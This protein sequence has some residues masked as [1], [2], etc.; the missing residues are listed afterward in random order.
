[1]FEFD[2]VLGGVAGMKLAAHSSGVA[3]I[4]RYGGSMVSV[5][6]GGKMLIFEFSADGV[7]GAGGGAAGQ[8]GAGDAGE[9]RGPRGADGAQPRDA[10]RHVEGEEQAAAQDACVDAQGGGGQDG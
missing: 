3:Y 9:A 5:D 7:A 10:Q 6:D 1:M 2:V 4:L 8:Q